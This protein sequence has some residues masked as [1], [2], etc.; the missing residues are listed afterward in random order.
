MSERK[1]FLSVLLALIVAFSTLPFLSFAE[2]QQAE[3]EAAE[4]AEYTEEVTDEIK[5]EDPEEINS[6]KEE[7][8]ESLPEED[9]DI[10]EDSNEETV[11]T[12]EV[13]VKSEDELQEEE[14]ETVEEKEKKEQQTEIATEEPE[15]EAET[16]EETAAAEETED[17]EKAP[18]TGKAAL[19]DSSAEEEIPDR[20]TA[21]RASSSSPTDIVEIQYDQSDTYE[22][23]Y[24]HETSHYTET[25]TYNTRKRTITK[26]K[27]RNGKIYDLEDSELEKSYFYCMEPGTKTPPVNTWIDVQSEL[28]EDTAGKKALLRKATYY[29]M[30]APGYRKVTKERWAQAYKDDGGKSSI[31]A[32]FHGLI[33]YLYDSSNSL[34]VNLDD[35]KQVSD[36]DKKWIK[37]WA[38]D[39]KNLDDPPDDFTVVILDTGKKYQTLIGAVY[40]EPECGYATV[41]KISGNSSITG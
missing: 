21:L 22:T 8:E 29:M 5:E 17:E 32:M 13:E 40:F 25:D 38:K 26:I 41:K 36:Y 11:Q 9:P 10:P 28:S 24:G 7:K 23:F 14:T 35:T 1:R 27:L 30:G 15:A 16:A 31:F 19:D 33:T 34:V 12:E 18:A 37:R 39:L 4:S 20:A 3:S 2:D 6:A